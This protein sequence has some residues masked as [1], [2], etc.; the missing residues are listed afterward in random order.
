MLCPSREV[1]QH[2]TWPARLDGSEKASLELDA[3]MPYRIDTPMQLVEALGSD[4]GGDLP[5]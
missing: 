3:A 2:G 5:R 4:S 1:T